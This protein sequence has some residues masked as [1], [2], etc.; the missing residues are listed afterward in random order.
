MIGGVALLLALD[1]RPLFGI[2][3]LAELRLDR[4]RHRLGSDACDP[5]CRLGDRASILLVMH[6]GGLLAV[7]GY[8]SES[9]LL[10]SNVGCSCAAC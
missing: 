5:D 6:R 10:V 8:I 2:W 4:G 3:A 1:A 9:W 7:P